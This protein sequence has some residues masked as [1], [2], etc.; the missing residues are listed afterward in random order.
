[1]NKK[2]IS[3][4]LT[5]VLCIGIFAGCQSSELMAYSDQPAKETDA[6]GETATTTKDYTP[7][8]ETYKPD[9][10]MLTVNGTDVTW[11]ELFYWMAYDVSSLESYFGSI[12]DWDAPCAFDET[13]TYKEYVTNN[14]LETVKHYCALESKA[15]EMNISLSDE[16][17]A[18]IDAQWKSNVD[19][20]SQGDEKAFIEYISKSFLTKDLYYHINSV[21][22]LY[23]KLFAETYGAKGEKLSEKEVLDKATEMGYARVKHILLRTVDDSYAALDEAAIAEKKATAQSVYDQLKD[24]S[25]P[26]AR[27]AKFDELAQQYSEDTGLAYQ[28][29]GYVYLP[30]ANFDPQF[31]A[32]A[33]A[34]QEN[35]LS[36]V[37]QSSMGYH[38]LLKLPLTTDSIVEYQSETVQ[39]YLPYLVAQSLFGTKTTEWAEESTVKLSKDYEKLDMAEIFAKATVVTAES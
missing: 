32:A 38:V 35:Q 1:M 5:A 9:K 31:M 16:D 12:T 19:S 20:Y 17:I 7:A 29:D 4:M 25:D 39:I 10:V 8:Y 33:N 11:G 18:A 28:P 37:V 3:L 23:E 36:E 21:S 13:I 15:K 26:T 34:L 6:A 30:D 27:E 24:I 14:A 22:K 2:I